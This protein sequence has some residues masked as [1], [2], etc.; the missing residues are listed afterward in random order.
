MNKVLLVV[1]SLGYNGA[2]MYAYF[3]SELLQKNKI[4]VTIWSY[5][6]GIFK[7]KFQQKGIEVKI[8][9]PTREYNII[10]KEMINY[11]YVLAF[12]I[13]TYNMVAI[14]KDI[15]PT[16]WYVHEGQNISEYMQDELCYKVL[17][18]TRNVWVVSEY[19]KE[20]LVERYGKTAKVIHNFVPDEF[21]KK[22]NLKTWE[23]VDTKRFLLIGNMI[24]RKAFDVYFD[25]FLGLEEDKKEACEFHYAGEQNDDS[26]YVI[27]NKSKIKEY[28][29]VINHGVVTDRDEMIALYNMC[30]V[31][32]VPSRDESCSLVTLEAAMMG[33]PVIVTEN[34]GAK[35]LVTEECG[36]IIKTGDSHI[37]AALCTDII[38]GKYNLDLMGKK[39]REQYLL[40]ATEKQYEKQFFA[41]MNNIEKLHFRFW[42]RRVCTICYKIYYRYFKSPFA[43]ASIPRGSKVILYG[44]GKNGRAWMKKLENS[45]YCKVVA[46]V[47]KYY[48]AEN[49]NG[50]DKIPK[51]KF[52]YVAVTIR[53]PETQKDIERELI[54]MGVNRE[55][56]IKI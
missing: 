4:H 17:K 52:D 44:A 29:N 2:P 3:V 32:V 33:K 53:K 11:D 41:E 45:R 10:I 38:N 50:I 14:C 39:A 26:N 18:R 16:I 15:V 13:L 36:W 21:E 28:N 35:Y 9:E 37:L 34:V 25:A 24:E 12:T 48:N 55:K 40:Y 1:H 7:D 56:I 27:K 49:I 8:V 51:L 6:D 23:N 30:D 46:W 5:S 31:V 54:Q 20:Y 47:D 22:C 42:R 19:A 43:G